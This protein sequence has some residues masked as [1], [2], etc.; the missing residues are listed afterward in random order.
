MPKFNLKKY[1]SKD[2]VTLEKMLSENHEGEPDNKITEKLIED[3]RKGTENV[4]TEKQ[5]NREASSDNIILEKQMNNGTDGWFKHRRNDSIPII[6]MYKQFEQEY[7]K[8]YKEAN[9]KDKLDTL[10]W[11]DYVGT[12]IPRDQITK[13]VGNEQ[14][15]QLVSNYKTRKEFMEK[16]PQIAKAA[17]KQASI[18]A[19]KDS[20]AM[21]YHIYRVAFENNR[22]LT[23]DEKMKIQDINA[24]KAKILVASLECECEEVC[25]EKCTCDK[26]NPNQKCEFCIEKE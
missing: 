15:S 22:D 6:E 14:H 25:E 8:A 20:D 2:S 11:D 3:N 18:E 26:S 5:I 17:S 13:I 19:L 4:I 1:S 10:F 24:G 12:Q 16:N 9:D 23:N 7:Q 21:I